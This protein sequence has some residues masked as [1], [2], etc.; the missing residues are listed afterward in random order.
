MCKSSTTQEDATENT[1][2]GETHGES[3]VFDASTMCVEKIS[4][5]R[6]WVGLFILLLRHVSWLR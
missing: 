2:P 3:R 4:T 6:V 5:K 1:Q